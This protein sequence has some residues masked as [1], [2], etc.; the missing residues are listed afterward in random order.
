MCNKK[1]RVFLIVALLAVFTLAVCLFCS[2][3]A[4]AALA[5]DGTTE[6]SAESGENSPVTPE[7]P[8]GEEIPAEGAQGVAESVQ[9][10]LKAIYGDDYEKYYNQI[11]ENW[12]SVEKYLLSASE[13]LPAEYRYKAAELLTTVNAYIGVGA[14]AVLLLCVGV[15]II[16]RA[17]KNKKINADLKTLKAC[18][19]QTQTAQLA[20]IQ[21]QKA[22]SA[23]LQKLLP[24][25]R[26]E[27]EIAEL[28]E[29]DKALDNAAE[30]VQKIV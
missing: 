11:I 5:D 7:A 15:Y 9:E 14:D 29:S 20:L 30:E 3:T 27:A 19:N 16:Y 21:S 1:L 28:I 10:Y 22:Q 2:Q 8:A 18:S 4:Y 6:I 13:N 17:K 24:G 23:S 12:G 25:E 26:F